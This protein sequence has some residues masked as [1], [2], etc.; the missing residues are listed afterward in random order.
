MDCMLILEMILS[1][2]LINKRPM[3]HTVY[4]SNTFTQKKNTSILNGKVNN[5]FNVITMQKQHM[6]S[7]VKD[8]TETRQSEGRISY[9]GI[10]SILC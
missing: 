2:N 4:Y 8:N 3:G 5:V 6:Q 1:H 9:N 7:R 10:V